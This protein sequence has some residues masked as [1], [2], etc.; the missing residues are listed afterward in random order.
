MQLPQTACL[1]RIAAGVA[2]TVFRKLS[3]QRLGLGTAHLPFDWT[4]DLALESKKCFRFCWQRP[5]IRS[6]QV[7]VERFLKTGFSD[8]F[9]VAPGSVE[10]GLCLYDLRAMSNR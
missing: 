8:F 9:C 1:S 3:I 4:L 10:F 2:K 6:T 5:R 7:G